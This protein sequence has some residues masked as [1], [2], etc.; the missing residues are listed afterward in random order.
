MNVALLL[1]IGLLAALSAGGAAFAFVGAGSDKSKKRLATVAKPAASVRAAKGAPVAWGHVA[2]STVSASSVSVAKR[3]PHPNAARLFT[4][5]LPT[6]FAPRRR[7]YARWRKQ[8]TLLLVQHYR[9]GVE[10][11]GLLLEDN[12]PGLKASLVL[13]AWRG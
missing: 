7:R 6:L 12:A 11:V 1:V 5:W 3:A 4:D 9:L 13:P 8:V 10:Q 2:P